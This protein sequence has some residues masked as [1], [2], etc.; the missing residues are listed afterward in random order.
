MRKSQLPTN[1]FFE[2]FIM[3]FL[4]WQVLVIDRTTTSYTT[5][6]KVHLS[7]GK[8]FVNG[9]HSKAFVTRIISITLSF[10]FDSFKS[11]YIVSR[12]LKCNSMSNALKFNECV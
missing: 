7:E 2:Q 8:R 5:L 1:C 9:S 11:Y 6:L 10:S 12:I 4:L 3:W